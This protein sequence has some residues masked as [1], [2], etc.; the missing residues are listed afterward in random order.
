MRCCF[1]GCK[2][3]LGFIVNRV[4]VVA[5]LWFDL[6]VWFLLVRVFAVVLLC[7]LGHCFGVVFL[8]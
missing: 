2:L 5:S 8:I 6:L 4:D 7:G 1:S 3:L